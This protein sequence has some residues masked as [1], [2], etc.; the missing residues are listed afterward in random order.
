MTKQTS[1]HFALSLAV[2]G[3]MLSTSPCQAQS[4]LV[5]LRRMQHQALSASQATTRTN[6][7]VPAGAP[8]YTFTVLA[9]PGTFFTAIGG[10]NSGAASSSKGE[11]K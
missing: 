2:L 11:L 3:L 1:T 7:T 5:G 8:S 6:Q 10:I 4:K 9:F